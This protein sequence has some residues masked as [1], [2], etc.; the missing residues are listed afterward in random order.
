MQDVCP[1]VLGLFHVASFPF[2]AIEQLKQNSLAKEDFR[3]DFKVSLR[4]VPDGP[5]R[6]IATENF[7][8]QQLQEQVDA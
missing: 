6:L 4:S 8:E 2:V 5:S 7:L 1:P 3:V